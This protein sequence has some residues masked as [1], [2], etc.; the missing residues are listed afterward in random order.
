MEILGVGFAGGKFRPWPSCFNA[1]Y[2]AFT[3]ADIGRKRHQTGVLGAW[4]GWRR[5]GV[6]GHHLFT[7]SFL[8]MR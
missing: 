5:F 8:N 4:L 7:Y 6:S 1:G 3:A 2:H